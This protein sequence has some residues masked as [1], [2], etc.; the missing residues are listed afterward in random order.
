[1]WTS[2]NFVGVW[3]VGHG[4]EQGGWVTGIINWEFDLR[5]GEMD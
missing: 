1:M 4:Y 3:M 5:V 2:D